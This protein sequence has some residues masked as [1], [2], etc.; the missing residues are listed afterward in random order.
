MYDPARHHRRS[1]RLPGYDYARSG[2]YLVTICTQNR[3][4]L[5]GHVIDDQMRL[6]PSGRTIHTTWDELP[7]QY[8]GIRNDA[9]VVMPNHIHAILVLTPAH[10]VGADPR[11][12]PPLTN[13]TRPLSL[14]EVIQRFKTLT[15][16][17]YIEG[18]ER[19]GWPAFTGRLWQRNYHEHIIR[20]E[21]SLHR[22]RQ[23]VANNPAQWPRDKENPA[24]PTPSS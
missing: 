2:R 7:N 17:R 9:F 14:P 8:P 3:T 13:A 20:T 21:R 24:N 19:H 4:C 11:V 12:C 10:P 5:F 15:T 18:V 16:K 22:L 1:I 6:N 23:Y